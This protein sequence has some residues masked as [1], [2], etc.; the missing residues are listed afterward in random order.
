MD[1]RNQKI[2]TIAAKQLFRYCTKPKGKE[3]QPF[4]F[5][6]TRRTLYSSVVKQETV[7]DECPL[8][9]QFLEILKSDKEAS[10]LCEKSN[11]EW[12]YDKLLI[13]DFE[14]IFLPDAREEKDE[15][16]QRKK[17]NLLMDAKDL[18]ENGLDLH[19]E[20]HDVHMVPFDKSG[21]MSRNG[22]IT[23]IA[24][25]YLKEMNERLN[26]G[27]DFS[28][29]EVVLSKYYAYRGLYLSTS[30][31]VEDE[32]F[33]ITPETLVIMQD[34]RT[35]IKRNGER[36]PVA[37]RNYERDVWLETAAE[38]SEEPGEWEFIAPRKVEIEY[39]DIPFDGEGIITE[40][41]SVYINDVLK[42]DGAT[43]YQIRMPYAK[44][45]LHTVN[46]HKFLEEFTEEYEEDKE[47]WYEDAFGIKRDL[48]KAH[49][50]LTASMFKGKEWI[51]KYCKTQD[52]DDPMEYYCSAIKKY[53]HGFYVSR[54]N[55]P[56]GHTKY[57]HL[58]YQTI[59]T[60]AFTENQ[61][62]RLLNRHCEL[63][64]EPIKF[65]KGWDEIEESDEIDKHKM[66]CELPNWQKAVLLNESFENDIY[67]K[68]ELKNIQKSLLT[69]LAMGKV[70]VEGQTRYLCRDLLP[71]VASL[72]KNNRNIR[73]FFLK[74]LWGCFYMPMKEQADEF[75][76]IKLNYSQYYAFFRNPHLARNEQVLLRPLVPVSEEEHHDNREAVT[77][78]RYNRYLNI[79]SRYFGHLTG[80]VMVPRGST[81]PLCLGGADFDGDLVH[82]ICDQD[83]VE[84][85]KKGVYDYDIEDPR[86]MERKLPVIKIPGI[87]P[88]KEVVPETVPY[89]HIRNTFSNRIG[90]ISNAAISIGQEEYGN[91]EVS[92]RKEYVEKY[93]PNKPSC[94]KC[95]LLTGLEI[96]AAKNGK[97]PN[98]DLILNGTQKKCE[99]LTFLSQFK[100][101]KEEEN[102]KYE[103]IEVKIEKGDSI[104]ITAKGCRTTVEFC[105]PKNG[106]YINR[107]P[108]IFGEKVLETKKIWGK[109]KTKGKV[110]HEFQYDKLEAET[111]KEKIERFKSDC[112]AVI[113]LN[114]FYQE[115]FLRGL[116]KEKNKSSYAV[117]NL[118][119]YINLIYDEKNA[120]VIQTNMIPAL[121]RKIGEKITTRKEI[122]EIKQ[123]INQFQWEFQPFEKRAEVL[124]KIIGNEF[125][126]STLN[127]EERSFLYHFNQQGYKLLWRIIES[128][129][130]MKGVDKETFE[131]MKN[132]AAK[133]K[134][135]YVL[136]KVSDLDRILEQEVRQYYENNTTYINEKIY[137]HCLREIRMIVENSELSL[138]TKVAALYEVT[139]ER[140]NL[141]R[142]KFFWEA[143]K[144]D[145]LKAFIGKKEKSHVK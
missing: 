46:V 118:E 115:L 29:M 41:Y 131:V 31:L 100:K 126:E 21:N 5:N 3:E 80:I 125:E 133:E 9:H 54:N 116:K 62:E 23:F 69:K 75:K 83:V 11:G 44:G 6:T 74:Y 111:S 86:K 16:I 137:R 67:I 72:L 71:L 91:G 109:K 7:F 89:R 117:E 73:D 12:L 97:H 15:R 25:Q 52:I 13:V 49:I 24:K 43:S 68:G 82:I 101:L 141:I 121:Q 142:R 20:D 120:D 4:Y 102:F 93:D 37:G 128:I 2:M 140:T 65:L 112:N 77:Y 108:M 56:Y 81:V 92:D 14:D 8:L 95:T 106:T 76:T 124:E 136:E 50:F 22:R 134:E 33:E 66:V 144:W 53:N 39:V 64:K 36:G 122:T 127:D 107:L 79:Y 129:E 87:V 90:Q 59:N 42:T 27:I 17:A 98:L 96:D 78:E 113:N 105:K 123:R 104:T 32:R 34:V 51:E 60:L 139:G 114:F 135:K 35:T 138:S 84:A 47:Y 63:I 55:L 28:D 88:I 57:T 143:F 1:I 26:L 45:M 61:F 94:S 103:N 48:K 19:F 18:I 110:L 99:Y 119:R 70:M 58:N 10:S 130:I 38:K 40:T 145:E 132:K 30:Q 85:V